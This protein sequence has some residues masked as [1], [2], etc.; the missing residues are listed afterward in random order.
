ML[1]IYL[2]VYSPDQETT[3]FQPHELARLFLQPFDNQ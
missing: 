2:A 1:Y 3:R